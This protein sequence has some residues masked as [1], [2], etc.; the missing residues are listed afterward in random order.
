[1]RLACADSTFP[2][3]SHEAAL[4]VIRD[5][6][7]SAVDVCLFPDG[8]SHT[9]PD[10]VRADPAAA[11]RSVRARTERAGLAVADVFLILGFA[12]PAINHPDPAVRADSFAYFEATVAFARALGAP[13]VSILPGMDFDGVANE[14]SLRLAADE[15]QRRAK[16]AGEAGLRLS[17]EPH[18][19]S[20]VETPERTLRL[21][22][23]APDA[24]LALDLSHYV[25]QGYR[26][27]ELDVLV[28]HAGHVHLRPAA[29]GAM[30]LRAREGAIDFVRLVR[31]LA[32]HGYDGYLTL[33]FQWE[34]W[35]DC[36]R[37]DCLSE[38]AELRD[39]LR[40]AVPSLLGDDA[41]T[42]P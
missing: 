39:V 9:P 34:E 16:L 12:E 20:I 37:V 4:T 38:T 5:L 27:D 22:E 1:M 8:S 18:Y 19:E 2:K 36:H 14:A 23:L 10:D 26:Q 15:L 24:S 25:Y 11:A 41:E 33:E 28:P 30:Q 21:R 7:M 13:G 17:Y 40:A 29:R 3:L 32:R 42:H 35:L 6:G 31:T